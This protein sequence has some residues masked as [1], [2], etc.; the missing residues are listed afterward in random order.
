VP[1]ISFTPL[2]QR[3]TD[4]NSLQFHHKEGQL[5]ILRSRESKELAELFAN[6]GHASRLKSSRP[7][8]EANVSDSL[9]RLRGL[10]LALTDVQSI[11]HEQLHTTTEQL[12]RVSSFLQHTR[13]IEE[14]ATLLQSKTNKR[15]DTRSATDIPDPLLRAPERSILSELERI[16]QEEAKVS[17]ETDSEASPE[18]EWGICIEREWS[19]TAKVFFGLCT[20]SGVCRFISSGLLKFGVISTSSSATSFSL[21]STA[22]VGIIVFSHL[23][24]SPEVIRSLYSISYIVPSKPDL[25]VTVAMILGLSCLFPLVCAIAAGVHTRPTI[26]APVNLILFIIIRLGSIPNG[27]RKG[28]QLKHLR[29]W[30]LA[31]ASILIPGYVSVL[32]SMVLFPTHR[33][34]GLFFSAIFLAPSSAHL[35]VLHGK[36]WIFETLHWAFLFLQLRVLCSGN[37]SSQWTPC[38]APLAASRDMVHFLFRL[39]REVFGEEAETSL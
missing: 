23:L 31:L 15:N 26:T 36:H 17:L 34:F 20:I 3:F 18:D 37:F 39:G 38:I 27:P 16:K 2:P 21:M 24:S 35:W 13:I 6:S 14:E 25:R 4:Q 19:T 22:L 29:F 33:D 10:Q 1:L 30:V 12:E 32:A 11:E 5:S 8:L 7:K 9:P 28:L